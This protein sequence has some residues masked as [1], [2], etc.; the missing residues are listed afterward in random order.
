M[1]SDQPAYGAVFSEFVHNSGHEIDPANFIRLGI[2]YEIAFEELGRPLPSY[3]RR[4]HKRDRGA[5]H[6]GSNAG[7]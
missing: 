6:L 5:L 7:F 1:V 4:V 3:R 2:E